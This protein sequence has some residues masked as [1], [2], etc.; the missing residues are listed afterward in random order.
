[1]IE[2]G[3][4]HHLFVELAPPLCDTRQRIDPRAIAEEFLRHDRQHL[5]GPADAPHMRYRQEGLAH[6]RHLLVAQLRYVTTR[7]EDVLHLR[8]RGHVL[9]GQTPALDVDTEL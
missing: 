1:M 8:P 7:N 9:E 6:V 2:V 4:N 5:G 3:M